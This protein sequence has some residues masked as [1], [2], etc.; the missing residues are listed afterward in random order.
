MDGAD[1]YH[2]DMDIEIMVVLNCMKREL[3]LSVVESIEI[4]Y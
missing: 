3:W 1:V 2:Y 4:Y